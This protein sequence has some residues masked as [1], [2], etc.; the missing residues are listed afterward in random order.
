MP[1]STFRKLGEALLNATLMLIALILLLVVVLV[2]Q[3]RGLSGEIRAD[4]AQW[5][6]RGEEA[7][8]RVQEAVVALDAVR[9]DA[10]VSLPDEIAQAR[11]ELTVALDGLQA[12]LPTELATDYALWQRMLMAAVSA[13]AREAQATR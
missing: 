12:R 5:Q 7:L 2:V 1:S 4:L 9:A 8:I 3:L 6:S 13:A 10:A 11:A